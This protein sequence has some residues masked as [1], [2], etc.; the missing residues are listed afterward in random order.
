MKTPQEYAREMVDHYL[1]PEV[2]A[3]ALR[4]FRLKENAARTLGDPLPDGRYKFVPLMASAFAQAL[5]DARA[6]ALEQCLE[7]VMGLV[8]DDMPVPCPDSEPG[9]EVF[10]VVRYQRRRTSH[11]V[12]Q[13]IRILKEKP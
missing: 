7:I 4:Q 13:L 10:H 2:F 6:A 12:E 1:E 5:A 9:C 11:E 3:E 8:E